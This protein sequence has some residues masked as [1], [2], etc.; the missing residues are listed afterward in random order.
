MS[1]PKSGKIKKM[2]KGERYYP[3]PSGI[4]LC[5]GPKEGRHICY[6]GHNGSRGGAWPKRPII[7]PWGKKG[8]W[9][10]GPTQNT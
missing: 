3:C 2:Y 8:W 10:D 4:R 7:L 6:R 5:M 9:G 1:M